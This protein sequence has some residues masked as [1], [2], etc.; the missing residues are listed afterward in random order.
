MIGR[1][2]GGRIDRRTNMSK[3]QTV[4]V[5]RYIFTVFVFVVVYLLLTLFIILCFFIILIFLLLLLLSLIYSCSAHAVFVFFA[6]QETICHV[7][8]LARVS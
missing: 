7:A 4:H 1:N 3:G 2:N 8:R 5:I 6:K